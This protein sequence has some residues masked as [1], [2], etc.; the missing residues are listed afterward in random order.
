M[1]VLLLAGLLLVGC[2]SQPQGPTY[3][4]VLNMIVNDPNMS[5]EEKKVRIMALSA[6]QQ[7][8]DAWNMHYSNQATQNYNAYQDSGKAFGDAAA[9]LILGY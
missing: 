7:H 9:G 5:W 1:R 4:D 2:A 8:L 3:S 6:E